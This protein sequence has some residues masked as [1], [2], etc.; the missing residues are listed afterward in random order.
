MAHV[1]SFV[2]AKFDVSR[3]APNPINP[4]AGE[5]VL[6]WLRKELT[7]AGYYCNVPETE[8]WGWYTHVGRGAGRYLIGASADVDIGAYTPGTDID[9]I[10][11]LHKLR[12]FKDKLFGRNKLARDDALFNAIVAILRA[13]GEMKQVTVDWDG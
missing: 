7:G 9:W 3:E 13:D 6:I 5:S 4:I 11:Q 2:T 12:S 8:D 1:V 10:V